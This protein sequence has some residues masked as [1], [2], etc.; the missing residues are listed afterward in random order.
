MR[1]RT[2]SLVVV[3]LLLAACSSSGSGT[4]GSR[5]GGQV[6]F[7]VDTT[8]G[9][10]YDAVARQLAKVLPDYYLDG[11][12][13]IVQNIPGASGATGID[14][15]KRSKPDGR[16]F[17]ILGSGTWTA[18]EQQNPLGWDVKTLKVLGAIDAPPYVVYLSAK[19]KLKSWQ[20][21][22]NSKT[23]VK[24]GV[25]GQTDSII[26]IAA[27][28]DKHKTPYKIARYPGSSQAELA[29]V[30]GDV[31]IFSGA[32]S[33]V[34]LERVRDGSYKP[35]FVLDNQRFS[36]LPDTPSAQ[37]LGMPAEYKTLHIQRI[38]AAP[39]GTPDD[40][41]AQL[42]EALRKAAADKRSQDF[43]KKAEIP[44]QFLSP[45]QVEQTNQARTTLFQQ[46][47]ALAT[48]YYFGG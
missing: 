6:Q 25:G 7:I 22:L 31:D 46:Y 45:E 29:T 19:S 5:S 20:D 32:A 26:A 17:G 35:A 21:V 3:A 39:P 15:M 42:S 34:T 14:H 30:S 37:E 12:S 43:A 9:G 8:P 47:S 48:K 27:E 2:L 13:V 36:E 28:L 16:T 44:M 38:L 40:V 33:G 24:I 18:L 1:V 4:S 23:T 11:A 41:V 10:A